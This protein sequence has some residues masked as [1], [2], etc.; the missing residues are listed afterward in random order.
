MAYAVSRKIAQDFHAAIAGRDPARI[1]S[2]VAD[3]V[4]WLMIGLVE[5]DTL[6]AA[7]QLLG[8]EI[9]LSVG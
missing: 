9:D 3:E 2:L 1:S 6:D 4:D 5:L 8:R 7:E